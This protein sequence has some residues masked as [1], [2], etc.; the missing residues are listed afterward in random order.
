MEIDVITVTSYIRGF[1]IALTV[2]TERFTLFLTVITYVL[3]GHSLTGDKVFSMAQFFNTI[4]LYMAIF[5]PLAVS[6]YAEAKISV[7]R[8]EVKLQLNYILKIYFKFMILGFSITRRN[9]NSNEYNCFARIRKTR[10][11]KNSEWQSKLDS[12]SNH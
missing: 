10:N 3:I 4:Q 6:F 8:I 12:A 1:L 9:I 5:Y 7:K 11:Y 2:F